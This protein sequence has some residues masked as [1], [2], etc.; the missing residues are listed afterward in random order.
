[1]P[2]RADD[3]RGVDCVRVHAGLVVMV[4][5]DQ[6]PIGHHTSNA[7]L[8]VLVRRRA[9]DQIFYSRS[10]EELD[11]RE[12]EDSGK[13]GRGEQRSVFDYHVVALVFVGDAKIREEGISWFTHNHGAEQLT[14]KPGTST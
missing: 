11:V 14:A 8:L 5:R 9:C 2:C 1:M 3:K 7:D 10:I 13:Q 12:A 6:G 4:H